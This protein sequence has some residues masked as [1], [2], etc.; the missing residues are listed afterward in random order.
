MLKKNALLAALL[1]ATMGGMSGCDR[2]QETAL[3]VTPVTDGVYQD[4]LNRPVSDDIFYFVLPDR[5]QNGD[6]SNDRGSEAIPESF[7]GFDPAD[8]GYYHGGDLAGLTEKLDYLQN[9]G[10]TAVWLTPVLR[11]QAVQ[12]D[13]SGYHGYWIL[14]FTQIDPHLGTNAELNKLIDTAH[15]KGM[16]V[17]FDIIVNHTADVI[18]YRECHNEDGSFRDPE[19]VLCPFKTYDQ[20][21]SGD[22]YSPFVAAGREQLKTPAWLNDPQY[23]NNRGDS[24]WVGES[25]ITGDFV[26]LDDLNTA[27]PRVVQGM[28]DIYKNIMTEFKPDGFRIDTVKHVEMSFWEAFSP[29]IMAHAKALGLPQFHVFGEVAQGDAAFLSRYSTIGK[30]PATLDFQ[31]FYTGIDVFAKGDSPQKL[32]KLIADD[33]YYRDHDSD[34][35]TKLTFMSNHDNGRFGLFINRA[36]P[37]SSAEEKLKRSLLSHAY[38][39]FSSGI[40]VVFYGDEQGFTGDGHDKDAREDMMP[41]Q[42]ASYNDNILL[43]SNASTAEDNFDETHPIYRAL[44]EYA[45]VYKAHPALRSGAQYLRHT[46]DQAGLFAFSRV[47]LNQ[48]DEYLVVFNTSTQNQWQTLAATA[49]SYQPVLGTSTGLTAEDGQVTVALEGLSFAIYRA[50]ERAPAVDDLTIQVASATNDLRSPSFVAIDYSTAAEK[51]YAL[52]LLSVKTEVQTTDGQ[53]ELVAVDD[54]APFTAKLLRSKLANEKA[55]LRVTVDNHAGKREVFSFE[56]DVR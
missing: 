34:A 19:S 33:D 27:D 23:Y 41:S 43:G 51:Q 56:I 54:N 47:D 28:I 44:A 11:N 17:F 8:K 26:G 38:M 30:M 14:D 10:V 55:T 22:Q 37:E 42:V 29:A 32:A 39:Y 12:A 53:F 18:S 49:E 4:Y 50:T 21:T 35:T 16:K 40:P 36:Q 9:M 24:I 52:P 48:G 13:S 45:S 6:P 20:I 2:H 5:F 31:H 46:S 3:V 7:G 15:S 1:A 25:V